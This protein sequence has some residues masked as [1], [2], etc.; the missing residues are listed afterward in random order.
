MG[1]ELHSKLFPTL[2]ALST[3]ALFSRALLT[4]W[5]MKPEIGYQW[6]SK[7]RFNGGLEVGSN[8][9][10]CLL[11]PAGLYPS[12]RTINF[13]LSFFLSQKLGIHNRDSPDNV[14]TP[15]SVAQYK[16]QWLNRVNRRSDQTQRH[17]RNGSR[18]VYLGNGI[19]L[20]ISRG[21]IVECSGGG[22]GLWWM[23]DSLP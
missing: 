17:S 18:R 22:C 11:A 10:Q 4:S 2:K 20:V 15:T 3:Q 1:F 7:L 23:Q 9:L 21:M 12:P 13:L 8:S 19:G 14:G 6:C 16:C 5:L